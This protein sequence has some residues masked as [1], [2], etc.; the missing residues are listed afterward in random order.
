MGRDTPRMEERARTMSKKEFLEQVAAQMALY[1]MKD[2]DHF[3]DSYIMK[4]A[5]KLARE[6]EEK[7]PALSW[8]ERFDRW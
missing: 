7:Y 2:G 6:L 3:S 5:S 8:Q 1:A 4:Q